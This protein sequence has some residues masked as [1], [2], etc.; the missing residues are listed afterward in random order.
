MKPLS[1]DLRQRVLAA[2]D[3][4]QLSHE[5]IAVQFSVSESWIRRLVQRRR[6]TGVIEPRPH[7]GG[8]PPKLDEQ[9]LRRLKELV[10]AQ[11]DATLAELRERL[12]Q[13]VG[14]M[15]IA[16]ALQRLQLPQKKVA[17]CR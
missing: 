15:T 10:L 9:A 11:R 17:T 16:R 13:P 12:G 5:A 14:I 7:G 4:G 2:V 1:I 8:R 6:E 3:A